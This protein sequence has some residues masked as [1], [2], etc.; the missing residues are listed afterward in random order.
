MKQ[1]RL[2]YGRMMAEWMLRQQILPML[3]NSGLINQEPDPNGDKRTK[4]V[5]LVGED[6]SPN[7]KDETI[8]E[9]SIEEL[10]QQAE[11]APNQDP[12]TLL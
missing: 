2:V 8:Q 4:L 11:I 6:N 5:F 12:Q 10:I 9:I 7:T 1:Y 3:E